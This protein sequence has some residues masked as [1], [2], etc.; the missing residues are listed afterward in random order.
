MYSE[1]NGFNGMSPRGTVS[2]SPLL[3]GS[4][5]GYGELQRLKEELTSSKAK[6]QQWEESMSQARIVSSE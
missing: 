1:Y 3:T 4:Y 2:L 6:L 5:G